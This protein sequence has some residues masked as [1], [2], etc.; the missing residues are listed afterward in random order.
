MTLKYTWSINSIKSKKDD[1][2]ED[3]VAEIYWRKT[4]KDEKGNEGFFDGLVL[5]ENIVSDS[6][7][8]SKFVPYNKLREAD[9]LKWVKKVVSGYEEHVDRSI[10]K[11]IDEKTN[12]LVDTPLP[13]V[14]S[15]K[16][17]K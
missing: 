7:E 9:V 8:P 1:K 12:A 3:I 16:T 11:Q 2:G 6:E 5:A 17:S 14:K 4:G 10:A 15:Q 13:W